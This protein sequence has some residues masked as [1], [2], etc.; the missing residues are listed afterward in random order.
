ME[1]QVLRTD[2]E[3]MTAFPLMSMLR[4]RIREDTLLPE[5]RRQQLQGYEIEI[6]S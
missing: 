5:V 2:A 3:I 4:D 1:I 6:A